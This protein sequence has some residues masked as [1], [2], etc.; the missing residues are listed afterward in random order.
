VEVVLEADP[1]VTA[2]V[3]VAEAVADALEEEDLVVEIEAVVAEE[4]L[5]VEIEAVVA[6][7][8]LVVEAVAVLEKIILTVDHEKCIKRLVLNV[9]KNVKFLSSQQKANLFI[10]GIVFRSIRNIRYK[11]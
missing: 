8:D 6:E 10:A 5:V 9:R 3:V 1:V 4:D 7:E 11:K 2:L